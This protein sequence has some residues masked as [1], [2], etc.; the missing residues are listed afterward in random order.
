MGL[1]PAQQAALLSKLEASVTTPGA[2][3]AVAQARPVAPHAPVA[4]AH[5][6]PAAQVPRLQL[7]WLTVW[8]TDA[9]DGDAV[10]IDSGGYSR[11]ITLTKA[12]VTFAV[13]VP[14]DSI[15]RVT[16]IRDGE[17]GGITVGLASG[18]SRAIFPIMSVGQA[19]GLNVKFN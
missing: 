7:A 2:P 11:T 8:D 15:L 14:G 13:P 19:L 4:A 12:P 5:A 9:E 17:G 16:G 6:Q 3:S 1:D 18:G 10:R